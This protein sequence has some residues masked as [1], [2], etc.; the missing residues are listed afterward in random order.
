M[1]VWLAKLFSSFFLVRAF[2][3]PKLADVGFGQ[4][5]ITTVIY[6][7]SEENLLEDLVAFRSVVKFS[8]LPKNALH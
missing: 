3:I 7:A 1:K 4:G 2:C 6:V 5:I 8:L